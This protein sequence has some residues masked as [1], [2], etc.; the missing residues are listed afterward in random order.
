MSVG[1]GVVNAASHAVKTAHC[2]NAVAHRDNSGNGR[3]GA[4]VAAVSSHLVGLHLGSW[5]ARIDNYISTA[6][7][8]MVVAYVSTQL[9]I[10]QTTRYLSKGSK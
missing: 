1:F 6:I 2:D 10:Y 4:G 9:R 8:Y 3:G 7:N 5:V